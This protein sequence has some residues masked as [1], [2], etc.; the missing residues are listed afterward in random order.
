MSL[1]PCRAVASRFV[2]VADEI[3]NGLDFAVEIPASRH[4]LADRLRALEWLRSDLRAEIP[5]AGPSAVRLFKAA[6]D[7]I[8]ELAPAVEACDQDGNLAP[9]RRSRDRAL[10]LLS[11]LRSSC[12]PEAD[13]SP[14]PRPKPAT[15]TAC[16]HDEQLDGLQGEKGEKVE[17]PELLSDKVSTNGRKILR[18]LLIEGADRRSRK[19]TSEEVADACNLSVGQYRR[20]MENLR[21]HQ[22]YI[23]QDGQ[24]GGVW[25]SPV[26]VQ[27]A[28]HLT[29]GAK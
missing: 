29:A 14:P 8:D 10:E 28:R 21:K 15:A 5:A 13:S 16:H 27:V 7:A 23:S 2:E 25:L 4:Q 3:A 1:I 6:T 11:T 20:A 12:R 19:W 17:K 22:L 9:W 18:H 26:G 24:D